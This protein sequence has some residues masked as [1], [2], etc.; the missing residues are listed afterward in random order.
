LATPYAPPPPP[1]STRRHGGSVIAP[2]LL[3]FVGGVLL[4]QN[5]GILPASVWGD[6]SRLWPLVLVLGGLELLVG[7]RLPWLFAIGGL[8]IVIVALGVAASSYGVLGG[9]HTNVATETVPTQL[10]SAQQAAVTV[11]FGAGLLDIGPALEAPTGQLAT[12]AF[13]GPPDFVPVPE[14][15]VAGDTGRLTYEINRKGNLLALVPGSSDEMQLEIDLARQVPITSLNIQAGATD[16]RVDLRN[17]RVNN[18]DME[19]GAARV[20]LGMPEAGVTTAHISGGA[21]Q[22]TVEVPP[23][24]AARIR[25]NGGLSGLHI[26]PNRFPALGDEINQSPDW[27][28][29]TNKVDITVETGFTT[30]QVN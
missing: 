16:A 23:G 20:W 2:L 11:N 4:L 17:L 27:D 5:A 21:F 8:A 13:T 19:V 7:R 22:M 18:V 28:T 26:D 10:Q 1:R 25:H 29:A 14:Y 3:I 24:V 12:M 30:I 15:A 6:L 9:A